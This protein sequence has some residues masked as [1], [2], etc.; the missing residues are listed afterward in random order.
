MTNSQNRQHSV[1]S[2]ED[3]TNA[4]ENHNEEINSAMDSNDS[5]NNNDITEGPVFDIHH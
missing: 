2:E 5:K 3:V 1:V 4:I